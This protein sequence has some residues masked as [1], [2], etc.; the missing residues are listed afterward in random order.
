MVTDN[1]TMMPHET[2]TRFG[3]VVEA[4][5]ERLVGQCHQLYDAPTLGSLVR[6]STPG[7]EKNIV[8]YAVVTGVA[9]SSLDPS[10]RIIARGTDSE[11]ESDIQQEYPHIEA[12]MRTDTTLTVVGHSIDHFCYQYLPPTPPRIHSFLYKCAAEEVRWFT[13]DLDF[14]AILANSEALS[15][16]EVVA[17][18][19]RC[20][21]TAYDRPDDFLAR[22]SRT[23]ASLLGRDTFHLAS[24]LRRLPLRGQ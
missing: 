11:S 2:A 5:I 8:V 18:T 23:L 10:R 3:E 15:K 1:W 20:A 21:A 7:L 6:T 22:A 13:T 9:T 16:D 24:I 12:L 14:L 17:A 4:S 19:V